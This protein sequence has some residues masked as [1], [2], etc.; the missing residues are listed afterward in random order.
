MRGGWPVL[1]LLCVAQ[2]VVVLDVTI[3]A[4]ALP[5]IRSDLGFSRAGLQWVVSAYTLVFGGF[6]MLAGRAADLYGRR[7][8]FVVGLA[9]FAGASLLCGLAESPA[10]LVAARV[11]QGLGAAIVSPSALSALTAAFPE[12]GGHRGLALGVWTAAAAGG[13]ATGWVLGGALAGGLGW[14]WVFFVNVPVGL[15]GVALAPFVLA[16]SRDPTSPPRLDVWG[17]ATVTAGLVL[18]VY[19]LTRAEALG[20]GSLEVAGSLSLSL[21]FIGAFVLVEGR[22]RYPLVPLGA[23]RSRRL[24]GANLVALLLTASTTPPMFLCTLYAQE[25]LGLPPVAAGLLFPPFNLAVIAGS[26]LGPRI[27]GAVGERVSMAVGLVAVAVGVLLLF[28]ISAGGGMGRLLPAFVLMGSGLGLASVASTAA[29]T[30]AA[31]ARQGLGS[32]L[33]NSA[34]QVG[35]AL[36][37]AVLVP[38]AAHVGAGDGGAPAALVEGYRW[39]FLG[40]ASLAFVGALL[41]LLLVREKGR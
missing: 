2:F 32:G 11:L 19:G 10:F 25:V 5:E 41:A 23:L 28:G 14:E 16:E 15:V 8:L 27:V 12:S 24:V 4:I 37:L 26:L 20:F 29:G 9:I 1:A 17:A 7:R 22:V 36:G 33:L 6:L 35:T 13:G 3:V 18:L 31:G 39:A 30:S 40:A 38:L 21:A 34:A